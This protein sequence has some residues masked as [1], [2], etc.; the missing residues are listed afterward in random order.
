VRIIVKID[1]L[2]IGTVLLFATFSQ[3]VAQT[4]SAQTAA[5]PP[6]PTDDQSPRAEPTSSL[7]GLS[8]RETQQTIS[9][10]R[11]ESTLLTYNKQSPPVPT[12][13]DPI[14]ARSG[15]LHPVNSPTGKTITATFPIDHAHQHG[16][17]AAWVKTTYS[18]R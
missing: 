11:G 18:G 5:Q 3:P 9:I 17:F 15:F 4:L 6:T 12:G 16:I 10:E 13:I 7:G 14:Y 8:V 1:V 2:I